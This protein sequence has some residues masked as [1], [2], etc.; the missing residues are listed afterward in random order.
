VAI[1]KKTIADIQGRKPPE[2]ATKLADGGGLYLYVTP[3]GSLLWRYDYRRKADG[4]RK[5]LSL[6]VYGETLPGLDLNRA[7]A[8]HQAARIVVANGG[9]P[10]ST[11]KIV[12]VRSGTFGEI[13]DAWLKTRT[14]IKP[15]SRAF[16]VRNVRYLKT[17]YRKAKG[18]GDVPITDVRVKHL[19]PL[20]SEFNKPSRV[21]LLSCA[22][23]VVAFAKAHDLIEHSPFAD[24]NFE[25]GFAPYKSTPRPAITNEKQFGDLLRKIDAYEG[26]GNSLVRDALQLLTL[27]FVRPGTVQAAEWE[28]FD[29][30]DTRQWVIPF[31]R[32]KMAHQ[33]EVE[34]DFVVPLS[35]QALKLLRELR[36][37]TGKGR[38]LFPG[39][40]RGGETIGENTLNGALWVLGFKGI[41]CAHGFRSSGSTI[42][43]RQRVDG[44]RRF[45][46]LLVEFQLDHQDATVRAIYD[47]DDCMP[48]RVELMQVW[49]DLCDDMRD[50]ED[51]VVVPMTMRAA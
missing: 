27:T 11:K 38:Y 17:G 7:R 41:H 42:L 39:N 47:R 26:R 32:L 28:H 31:A 14:G 16:D 30:D 34:E 10:A 33:R 2:K 37:I 5:T 51:S 46:R 9:D 13:A 1:Q 36:E 3:S 25:A 19:S 40:I 45:E 22:K 12:A 18:F 44:R 48:E 15:N 35:R 6:G 23:M 50:M 43:N 4:K 29:L 49:A 24:I 20:L 8:A 21:R